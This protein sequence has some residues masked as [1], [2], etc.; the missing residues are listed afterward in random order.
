LKGKM[1]SSNPA[2]KTPEEFQ[3]GVPAFR[4][5]LYNTGGTLMSQK[6]YIALLDSHGVNFTPELKEAEGK[7]EAVK[8]V[9]PGGQAEYAQRMINEYKEMRINPKRVFA[10][11]FNP[12]DI[13][14]WLK[15]EPA[16]GQQ[17]VWLESRDANVNPADPDD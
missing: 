8:E 4:T 5:N 16:F 17:A 11:S 1:D 12:A 6:E 15:N 10:Q 3:G 14:Y 7:P 9:F 2:A 13:F